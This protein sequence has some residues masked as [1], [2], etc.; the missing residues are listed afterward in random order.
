M[1][2][3][4]IRGGGMRGVS[5]RGGVSVIVLNNSIAPMFG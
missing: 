3:G 4:A 5:M 2:G 1:R